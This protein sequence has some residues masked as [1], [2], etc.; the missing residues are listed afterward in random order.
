MFEVC[1]G[2]FNAYMT[3]FNCG[4]SGKSDRLDTTLLLREYCGSLILWWGAIIYF[5]GIDRMT[6]QCKNN[7]MVKHL[8]PD[9]RGL[10][11]DD[12]TPNYR[13]E[14]SRND[15]MR[16]NDV[17]YSRR[18]CRISTKN[19]QSLKFGSLLWLKT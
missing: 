1:R 10:V 2:V 19:L 8:Y 13:Y 9:G 12:S 5:L 7:T 17:H 6:C 4:S 14:G 18:D 3:L 16:M 11:Q 15:L